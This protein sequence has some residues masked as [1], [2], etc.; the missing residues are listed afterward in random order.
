MIMFQKG[1][2]VQIGTHQGRIVKVNQDNSI[3]LQHEGKR[4]H[5]Y[6]VL[7]EKVELSETPQDGTD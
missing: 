7:I 1:Q 3:G 4:R 5:T 2:Y 6:D